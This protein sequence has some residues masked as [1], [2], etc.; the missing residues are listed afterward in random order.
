MTPA[1]PPI[2]LPASYKDLSLKDIRISHYPESSPTP[3]PIIILTLYRPGR[4]NAFT[5]TM[6]EEL[7]QA[8]AMFDVDERVKCII[9]TGHGKI[10]C[11]GADL[12]SSFQKTGEKINEHRDGGGRV[13]MAIYN[14]RKPT[15][16]AMNGAAVGVGIT[17]C[18]P[19][20][21]RLAP[22][23]AKIGFVFARRGLVMEAASSFFLPKLVGLSQAMHLITTG[24][25]YPASHKLLSGIFSETLPTA[26]EVLPRAIEL[27]TEFVENCSG[28]S[29]AL[30]KDMMWRN[31]GTAEEA[32][33]LDSRIIYDL[34]S[35]PD[36]K[37]GVKSFLEK[38]K[39]NFVGD[40]ERDAPAAYPWWQ[41]IDIVE[42]PKGAVEG[43][44]KL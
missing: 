39:V 12:S 37:E 18:L 27:A 17:M 32:H 30:M 22:A 42:R 25:T 13:S 44:S 15:I 36:N 9:V 34:F 16:A 35:T 10:F 24:S 28:V 8:F 31:P 23:N 7:E 41:P 43:K 38:R 11:A 29:W 2:K 20:A 5:Y 4:H 1:P 14:C 40:I 26:E 33:L 21:I 3:T 19:M 6:T